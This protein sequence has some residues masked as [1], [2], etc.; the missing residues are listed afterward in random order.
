MPAYPASALA[1]KR[2]GT[3]VLSYYVDE[4]GRAEKNLLVRTSG[5]ADL[6]KAATDAFDKCRFTTA[7]KD[8]QRVKGWATV[9]YTWTLPVKD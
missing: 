6:D 8:G 2:S 9:Y 4:E 5:H 1:E 3:V 7:V